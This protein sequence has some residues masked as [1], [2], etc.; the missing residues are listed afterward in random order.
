MMMMSERSYTRT[1][2]PARERP[3]SDGRTPSGPSAQTATDDDEAKRWKMSSAT[4]T[5]RATTT[6]RRPT[7]RA[8]TRRGTSSRRMTV[9]RAS[10]AVSKPWAETDCRLVLEDGSVWRGRSFGARATQVGEVV[11]NTSL[12]GCVRW[13][14]ATRDDERHSM[15]KI[16]LKKIDDAGI[17]NERARADG[18]GGFRRAHRKRGGLSGD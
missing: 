6:Q 13:S 16:F 14:I 15:G 18:R 2:P 1:N 4:T 7:T 5:M 17:S 3:P 11:F 9:T 12:S 10:A 8:A